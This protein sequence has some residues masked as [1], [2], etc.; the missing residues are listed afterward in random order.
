MFWVAPLIGGALGGVIYRWFN[1]EPTGVV[2]G[3]K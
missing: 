3:S 2:Q 1:D